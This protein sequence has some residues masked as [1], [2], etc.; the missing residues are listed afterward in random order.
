MNC[1]M[2]TK[3][4]RKKIIVDFGKIIKD[5]SNVLLLEGIFDAIKTDLNASKVPESHYLVVEEERER[6]LT[7]TISGISWDDFEA[8]LLKKYGF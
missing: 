8:Q 7:E 3:D 4:V 2:E 6:Y 5:D 1:I